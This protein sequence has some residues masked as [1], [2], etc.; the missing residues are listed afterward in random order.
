MKI[1]DLLDSWSA[2]GTDL[3][4]F[5]EIIQN[6]ANSTYTV[7]VDTNQLTMMHFLGWNAKVEDRMNLSVHSEAQYLEG[8]IQKVALNIAKLKSNAQFIEEVTTVA[9]LMMNLN[10][11]GYQKGDFYFTSG[12]LSRDLGARANLAGDAIYDATD[13][14]DSYIMSRYV[15]KPETATAVIRYDDTNSIHKV[16]ALA[17]GNYCHIDQTILLDMIGR[18]EADLGKAECQAWKIDHFLTQIWLTF[19]ENADDI[20]ETYGLPDK[21]IPGVLLETSDSGD[22]SLRAVAYWQHSSSIRSRARIGLYERMHRGRFSSIDVLNTMPTKLM[23]KY[24]ELPNRLAEL[25]TIDIAEPDEVIAKILKMLNADK[26]IGKKRTKN[27]CDCLC[28]EVGSRTTMTAYELAVMFMDLPSR[29][30]ID[31]TCTESIENMA[32]RAPFVNFAKLAKS[33]T[34]SVVVA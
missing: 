6:V 14:R 17:S 19:P 3:N 9:P 10:H 33:T 20:C 22:C 5:K 2:S 7:Q 13:D 8:K 26:L 21:F 23:G 12:H 1:L 15:K 30:S 18:L 29:I 27:L 28:S 11:A 25:L 24:M 31:A 32:G 16:F 34:T 4:E